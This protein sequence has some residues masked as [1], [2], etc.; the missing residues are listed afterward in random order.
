MDGNFLFSIVSPNIG[1][2]PNFPNV[3]VKDT[4]DLGALPGTSDEKLLPFLGPFIDHVGDK[5]KVEKMIKNIFFQV[6]STLIAIIVLAYLVLHTLSGF[7]NKIEIKNVYYTTMDLSFDS[8]A[9]V[10]RDEEVLSSKKDGSPLYLAEN[11]EKIGINKKVVSVFTDSDAYES[12][13]KIGQLEEKINYLKSVVDKAKYTKPSIPS[14]DNNI[15]EQIENISVFSSKF[16][17]KK[18]V[19][20]LSKFF[21]KI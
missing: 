13:I 14:L 9:Y 3:D 20:E 5:S 10:F 6:T 12:S 21:H 4:K 2:F 15:Y 11:G 7:E 19:R 1:V 18:K 16:K 17:R 8:T